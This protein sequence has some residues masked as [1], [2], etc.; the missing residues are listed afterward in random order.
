M[1]RFDRLTVTWHRMIPRICV[2]LSLS[3]GELVEG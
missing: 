1:P 3:K 2:T